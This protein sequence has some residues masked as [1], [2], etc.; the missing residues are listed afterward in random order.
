MDE[1]FRYFFQLELLCAVLGCVSLFMGI[2]NCFTQ[3]KVLMIA[4]MGFFAVCLLNFLILYRRQRS[5]GISYAIFDLS[6]LCLFLYF[7]LTGGTAGFSPHWILLLP[8]C[9]M[10]LL[11][12]KHGMFLSSVMLAMMVFLLWTPLGTGLLRYDYT[13]EFRMRFPIV[14]IAFFVVGYLFDLICSAVYHTMLQ[15]QKDLADMAEKDALTGLKNRFWFNRHFWEARDNQLSPDDC[16]VLLIDID[17]F[18]VVN[19]ICGHPAGDAVLCGVSETI[20]SMLNSQSVVC[21]WGGEEFFVFVPQC[22]WPEAEHLCEKIR[23]AVESSAYQYGGK[24]DITVTVSIGAVHIQADT[25]MN[26]ES[27]LCLA[28]KKLYEAKQCGKNAVSLQKNTGIVG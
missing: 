28:D 1:N 24:P 17:D 9:G 21:R 23:A 14:Y 12:R 20:C 27:I 3:K 15:T 7:L 16:L 18:K 13:P 26:V 19:D 5:T 11:G 25:R 10:M 4:T 22:G 2:L 8:T 6:V